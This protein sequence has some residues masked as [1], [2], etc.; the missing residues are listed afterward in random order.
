LHARLFACASIACALL[1]LA[2]LAVRAADGPAPARL[3][4]AL[5]PNDAFFADWSWPA[6]ATGLEQAWDATLGSAS[7]TIAILDTGVSPVADL[8]GALLPGVD[9][10]NGDADASDD[11]GHG[12]QVAS[13][14]A[15]RTNNG[16]GIAGVCGGCSILPVK[17]LGA[18]GS[19]SATTVAQ[20]IGWAV[21][22]GARVVNLSAAGPTDDPTLDAAIADAVARGA[23]VVV[24]A[25][26]AGS[27]DPAAGG[28]PAAAAT[29]A[30]RVAGVDRAGALYSWSNRGPW[31]D[32]AAPGA[33]ATASRDGSFLLGSQGTS[34]AAPIVAG[35]AG[36][37][38]SYQPAL[39]PAAVKSLVTANGTAAAGLDVAS[40]RIVNAAA[41]LTA[42][43]W[44]PPPKPVQAAP[45]PK[46][47]QSAPAAAKK[48]APAKLRTQRK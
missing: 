27:A 36:L 21:D 13:V 31:V 41:A 46:R 19:G 43:G 32:V 8:Q 35:V 7:V 29:A 44:T 1:G 24:A 18:D 15:A 3:Q 48:K 37:L 47:V 17:V 6:Q 30:I 9:L 4:A 42:L 16:L 12:T 25:G 10:V 2:A 23:V 45:P 39:A 5:A 11:N 14:A 22:H 20:G 28:Y 33:V 26:N 38:L 34:L 40:G